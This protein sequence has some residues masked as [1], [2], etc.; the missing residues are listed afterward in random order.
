MPAVACPVWCRRAMLLTDRAVVQVPGPNR[1]AK[2]FFGQAVHHGDKEIICPEISLAV[3]L[4]AARGEPAAKVGGFCGETE[5]VEQRIRLQ[6]LPGS[7]R[8][9]RCA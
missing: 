5:V 7:A 1:A 6:N 8:L 3:T 9:L 2:S 4:K